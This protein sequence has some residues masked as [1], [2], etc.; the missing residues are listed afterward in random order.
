ME[1]IFL[2]EKIDRRDE[3]EEDED[4]APTFL[5]T[6]LGEATRFRASMA[7]GGTTEER[8]KRIDKYCFLLKSRRR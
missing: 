5:M 6:V 7:I 4:R 8:K 3:E 2:G 1:G